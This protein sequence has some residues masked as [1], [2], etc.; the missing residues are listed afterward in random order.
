MEK[1]DDSYFVLST[2]KQIYAYDGVI[3]LNEEMEYIHN[4]YD[5]SDCII[6]DEYSSSEFTPAEIVEI[7][8]YM[9]DLWNKLK[10]KHTPKI[11]EV[12]K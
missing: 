7:C 12:N 8:D 5:G 4:G 6:G 9:I 10:I 1:T 11:D 2:G 3:G